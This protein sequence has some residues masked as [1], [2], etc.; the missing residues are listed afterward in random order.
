GRTY[1]LPTEAEWEYACRAKTRTVFHFGD[2]ITPGVANYDGRESYANGPKGRYREETTP[3]TEFN[4]A[5][6]FGLSDMHGNVWEWC[7]DHWHKNYN[8][9]PGDGSAWIE[10]GSI[11]GQSP[12]KDQ[13]R[14]VRGGSWYLNP[15][16]CRSAS[17]Y[18]SNPDVRSSN[19]GFRVVLAPR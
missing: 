10:G 1:R 18:R 4:L 16:N 7:L 5:N 17:R 2:M 15:R 8:G 12:V 11:D 3:V 9:A 19:I 14:V 6:V 13:R